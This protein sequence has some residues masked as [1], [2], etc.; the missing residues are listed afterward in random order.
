M[1]VELLFLTRL[2]SSSIIDERM[3]FASHPG[4]NICVAYFYCSYIYKTHQPLSELFGCLSAQISQYSPI[5]RYAIAKYLNRKV[6]YKKLVAVLVETAPHLECIY[7]IIDAVDEFTPLKDSIDNHDQQRELLKTLRKL[8]E[9]G[10]GRIKVLLTSRLT[11]VIQNELVQVPTF[12]ITN[13]SNI[14]DIKLHM[15]SKLKGEMNS[16]TVLG[17]MLKA[18]ETQSPK[19]TNL[20]ISTIAD[21]ADGMFLFVKFQ[22]LIFIGSDHSHGLLKTLKNLPEDMDKTWQLVLLR[23][24]EAQNTPQDCETVKMVLQWLVAA[25]RPLRLY[26]IRAAVSVRRYQT[27]VSLVDNLHD[28]KWLIGLCGPLVSLTSDE[29]PEEREISLAHFTLKKYLVSGKLQECGDHPAREY[30]IVPSEANVYLATV[31]LTYLASRELSQPFQTKHELEK[32]RQEHKLMDYATLHGGTH[33]AALDR[34]DDNIIQLLNGLFIPEITWDVLEQTRG[35]SDGLLDVTFTALPLS[36]LADDSDATES[37]MYRVAVAGKDLT[38]I[39]NHIAQVTLR[40]IESHT[41]CKAFVQL[42]RLLSDRT[43]KDHPSHVTALYYSALFGWKAGVIFLLESA[44]DRVTTSDLNHALRAAAVGGFLEIIDLLHKAGANPDAYMGDLGSAIQSAASCGHLDVARRLLD[45]G[46]DL[47]AEMPYCRDGGTVGSSL[48]GAAEAGHTELMQLLIDGGADLN[49]NDGW[50]GT[51]LQSILEKGNIDIAKWIIDHE[52][53]K[54]NVT[55][56]YYGSVSRFLCLSALQSAQD[57]LEAVLNRGGSP[58]ERVGVYGSLL[59]IASH[60]GFVRTIELLLRRG[61]KL[62]SCSMGQ[63]GNAVHAAA[64]NGDEKILRLLLEHGGNPN[65]EGHWLGEDFTGPV[66]DFQDG[67]G[68]LLELVQGTGFL[69]YD[70][71]L[72]TRAFYAPAIHASMRI[73]EVDHNKILYLFENEPTH[74]NGH[75]GN[76][77]QGA[78]FRGNINT[79]LILLIKGADIDARNGFFGTALQAAVSQNHLEAVDVLLENGAN[80]NTASA[81]YYGSALAA[82]TVLGLEAIIRALVSNGARYDCFDEHGW[83]ARTWQSLK[84]TEAIRAMSL[85]GECRSPERWSTVN[86]SPRLRAD[87]EGLIVRY[88]ESL[89]GKYPE[90][91]STV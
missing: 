48:Q 45:L 63:F 40:S 44:K 5:F 61:A 68:Q 2:S 18:G 82:A 23:V 69:A 89:R 52:D 85:E 78:A 34:A 8:Q 65:C 91:N 81:G 53:F 50:L 39:A 26:E 79:M 29:N 64:M 32:L 77:L 21:K 31:S 60:F 57:L 16:Q 83:S 86:I 7:L 51:A 55:G 9:D 72:V 4:R 84:S 58:S 20:I 12:E 33:L 36:H 88:A 66:F 10:K 19:L 15:R 11:I 67:Y 35:H 73:R 62:D 14:E 87:D 24:H 54:P 70:H 90:M 56:G 6:N 71:S 41:N 43:R 38:E 75:L 3:D 49:C 42:F 80:P 17:G 28:P 25:A 27:N 46:A 22:I 76:P 30:N 74:R 1:S 13:Q 59:E 47:D 37:A